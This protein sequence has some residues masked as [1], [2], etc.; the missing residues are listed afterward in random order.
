MALINLIINSVPAINSLSINREI[1]NN[2]LWIIYRSF[3]PALLI[4][5]KIGSQRYTVPGVVITMADKLW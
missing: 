4:I 1:A 3:G 5:E 2:E